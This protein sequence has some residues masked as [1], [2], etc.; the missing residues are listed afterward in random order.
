M[1]GPCNLEN[2]GYFFSMNG[3]SSFGILQQSVHPNIKPGVALG[4]EDTVGNVTSSEL[5]SGG[6]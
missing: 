3:S 5:S 2:W 6:A 1:P 4:L